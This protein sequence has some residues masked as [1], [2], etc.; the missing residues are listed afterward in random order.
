MDSTHYTTD[1][2]PTSTTDAGGA[3]DHISASG[4][5]FAEQAA[6]PR[7]PEC[8]LWRSVILQAL[9][10]A[11]AHSLSPGAV[12]ER[13]RARAWFFETNDGFTQVCQ[14][15]GMNPEFVRRKAREAVESGRMVV[16]LAIAAQRRQRQ[17]K[18]RRPY[19]RRNNVVSLMPNRREKKS[20]R[21]RMLASRPV[22][23]MLR[24]H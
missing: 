3:I 6:D 24:V 5:L 22:K 16:E 8:S 15:A 18:K 10:D 12:L 23:V 1:A 4:M 21:P 7:M 20:F 2:R 17:M 19:T 13:Q 14:L 11:C 9:A